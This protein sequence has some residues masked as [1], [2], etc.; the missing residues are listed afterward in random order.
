MMVWPRYLALTSS[1]VT[2]MNDPGQVVCQ[3][4]SVIQSGLDANPGALLICRWADLTRA[5]T[6]W[7]LLAYGWRF[8]AS[9]Y[10]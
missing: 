8:M 4:N 6:P 7:G 5:T 3:P 9:K 2:Y 10:R 1:F